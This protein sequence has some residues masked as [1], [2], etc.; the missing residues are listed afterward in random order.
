MEKHRLNNGGRKDCIKECWIMVES[1]HGEGE[2]GSLRQ[3]S[4]DPSVS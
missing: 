2:S 4:V 3:G 1:Q